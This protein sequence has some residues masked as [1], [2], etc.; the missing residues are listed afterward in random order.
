M[1]PEASKLLTLSS[2]SI[3]MENQAADTAFFDWVS[4][5]IL[6]DQQLN[7]EEHMSTSSKRP[8]KSKGKAKLTE[9]EM[10]YKYQRVRMPD[11]QA[12]C[13]LDIKDS[14]LGHIDLEEFWV[15]TQKV[16]RSPWMDKLIG[17]LGES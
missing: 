6:A 17:K 11:S 9:K 15:R 12:E 16:T 1:R 13:D 8:T 5:L 14:E 4:R 3:S 7:S 10:K 2:V